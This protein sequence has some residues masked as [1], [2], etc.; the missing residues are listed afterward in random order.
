LTFAIV[1]IDLTFSDKE[2][3]VEE[4]RYQ[5]VKLAKL[6]HQAVHQNPGEGHV[7][8]EKVS[9][10]WLVVLGVLIGLLTVL[11]GLGLWY[12]KGNKEVVVKDRVFVA[13]NFYRMFMR[14]G[15]AGRECRS[16]R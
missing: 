2:A 6:H 8:A 12:I 14:L 15:W 4:I 5:G 13:G 1:I 3:D 9:N 16:I 10:K 7:S 11:L